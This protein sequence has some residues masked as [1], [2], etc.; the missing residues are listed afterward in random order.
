M[1][2]AIRIRVRPEEGDYDPSVSKF[3]G[4]PTIPGEWLSDFDEYTIF[5]CQIRLADIARYDKENRLPHSGYLYV[6]LDTYDSEFNLSPIVRYYDGEPDTVVDEFNSAVPDYEDFDRAWLIDFELCDGCE[7]GTRLFG[8]PRTIDE[9]E[10]EGKLLMQFDPLDSEMGF[11]SHLDGYLYLFFGKDE[12]DPSAVT[13]IS[14]F[15]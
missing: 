3:F 15:S 2:E 10:A 8:T 12:S 13:A 7:D 1:S 14:D 5:F 6:F 11:L 4:S 9:G